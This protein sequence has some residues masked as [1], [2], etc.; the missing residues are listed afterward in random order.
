MRS[1]DSLDGLDVCSTNSSSLGALPNISVPILITTM[2]G[3]YF[4]RDS[5]IEYETAASADKDFIAVEG[6]SH[7]IEPCTECE[8]VPGQYSNTVKNYFDYLQ[9]W[10]NA[11]F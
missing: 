10:I 9:K 3:H 11:R 4:V 6:A 5:E 8:K 7:G 1:T 2:T